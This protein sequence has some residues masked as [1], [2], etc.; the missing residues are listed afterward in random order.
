MSKVGSVTWMTG[1]YEKPRALVTGGAGFIGS[2]LC[3]ALLGHGWEVFV[4]DDLST[5]SIANVTHLLPRDDFHLVV[6]TVLNEAVVNSLIYR[7]D[8]VWHLA[9]AVGVKLIVEQPVRTLV[10]NVQG[11]EVVLDLC[12]RF[13][14]PVLVASTSEVYGDHKSLEPLGEEHSR[15]YGPTHVN[16]WAYAGSKALDEFLALAYFQERDLRVVIARLFN[17][18][19]PRQT[20]E[21]GMVV[22]ALVR[23]AIEGKPLRVFGD[24]QQTRCFCHV[25][26]TVRALIELMES[27]RCV[28]RIFNVGNA[29]PIS[30]EDLARKI[31]H[32]AQSDS[33]VILVSYE[34]AYGP[35]FEDMRHRVP[36]IA[37]IAE[38]VGWSPERGLDEILVDVIAFERSRSPLPSAP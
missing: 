27:P 26:D 38:A 2:H 20:G 24:G 8:A 7:V 4:I 16:R 9:A 19:G 30:I 36:D 25:H 17:T 12:A 33:E 23:Q 22:P 15:I 29:S 5:G 3:E 1:A 18:V 10:T 13:G 34:D 11:T 14:K 6:D 21:Y 37:L 35:G 32:L 31:L 28:G